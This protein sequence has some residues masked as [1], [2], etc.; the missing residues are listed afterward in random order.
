MSFTSDVVIGLEI[1]AELDTE[2][3][4]FCG[5]PTT[6]SEEPNTRVCPI[7]L[8]HPG[9]RPVLNKKAV[10]YAMKLCLA[11]GAKVRDEHISARKSYFYPDMSKNFQITQY[12]EP[13]GT[14]GGIKLK[15]GKMVNLTR[16]HMEEDP[17]AITYPDSMYS[18]T[19]S[20]LDYNRCGNPLVEIVTEP[21]LESPAEARD[22][23]NRLISILT[24]LRIFDINKCII[25]ADANMSLKES[26][27]T[28]VEIKNITG[29]KELERA[30]NYEITR[31][32]AYLKQGLKVKA[33][34]TRGWD[35]ASKTTKLL[36]TKESEDDYGYIVEPDLPIIDLTCE[37]IATIE[38]EIPELAHQKAERYVKDM[39]IDPV[40]ADV[41]ALEL[42]LA[43]LFER[44]AQKIDPKLAAR[45]LRRELMRVLNYNKQAV[46]DIRFDEKQLI[47]LLSLVDTGKISDTTGQKI[48]EKLMDEPFSPLEYVK[49]NGLAQI[50]GEDEIREACRQAIKDNPKAVEDYRNGVDKSFM[51]LVGQVMRATRGKA[52]P[53]LT[54][55]IMEEEI[56]K[57]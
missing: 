11:V 8:G 37:M 9:S 57:A 44:V 18:S 14:G 30:L 51:F 28:R 53:K 27:Y 43:E 41:M 54:N 29:F 34:E 26:G 19:Y 32:K 42:E 33:M 45:W 50:T 2:T 16:I 36:R 48:M 13:V 3:K 31:Q 5:C 46:R 24:Y 39:G 1:H 22:F 4:M 6:G 35:D 55:R 15:T 10:D 17:A 52:E 56:G 25:K 47:E 40:D 7:C 23:L 20:Y 21:E 49:E 38:K 12:D